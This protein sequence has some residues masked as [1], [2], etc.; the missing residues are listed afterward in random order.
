MEIRLLQRDE[1][2]TPKWNGCVHYARNSKI[3]GYTWY[4]DNV[5]G[6]WMGLVEGDYESVFPLVWNDKLLKIKQLYQPFLSQQLGLFSVNL[7]SKERLQCFLDMI[8]EV[9]KYWD[10]ALNDGNQNVL[11]L[12]SYDVV[13]KDN[14]HLD[15]NKPYDDLYQAYSKNIKRNIKKAVKQNLYL[16]NNLKAETF[17]AEVKKAQELKGVKHPDALYHA[18]HRIIYNC[19][20]R[21]KGAISAAFDTDKNLCAAIFFMFDGYAM[22]NLLNVS[23]EIGKNNGAMP[24]LL[25]AAIMR[26]AGKNKY[27]DFEGS[28]VQGI[29][30]FYQSFGAKNVPY[31][32]LTN[33]KLPWWL[34]WRKK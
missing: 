21:G 8:P 3:Y 32:Q 23:T 1:I 6:E 17:V 33:N 25:D 10:V 16:T 29:A 12:K 24:Y 2:E 9:Y 13:S 30:R 20:H 18:S 19:L 11:K 7:C 4:L 22:I 26:E 27:I 5:A 28:S 34:K 15:L 14:Y 31:Y